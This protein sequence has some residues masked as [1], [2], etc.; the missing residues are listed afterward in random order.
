MPTGFWILCLPR[1]LAISSSQMRSSLRR[2]ELWGSGSFSGPKLRDHIGW[3]CSLISSHVGLLTLVLQCFVEMSNICNSWTKLK[4]LLAKIIE[5]KVKGMVFLRGKLWVCFDVCP[6]A[7]AEIQYNWHDSRHWQLTVTTQQLELEGTLE[8]Y[9]D[10]RGEQDGSHGAFR[11]QFCGCRNYQKHRQEQWRGGGTSDKA[12]R[13]NRRLQQKK[14][15]PEQRPERSF[16]KVVEARRNCSY[17]GAQGPSCS[18]SPSASFLF[19]HC[20]LI[21][22]PY[23]QREASE[24]SKH[25]S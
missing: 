7:V 1:P 4:K 21:W 25:L 20:S 11:G 23:L 3:Q 10:G 12:Q 22:P 17:W 16:S 6:E 9:L 13:R 5:A 24:L 2:R 8:G 19:D 18:Q 15:I 14:Q